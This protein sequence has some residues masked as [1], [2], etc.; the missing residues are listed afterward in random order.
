M[1]RNLH[2]CTVEKLLFKHSCL[3]RESGGDESSD[4]GTDGSLRVLKRKKA[5]NTEQTTLTAFEQYKRN[6]PA[7][8]KAILTKMGKQL[9]E[10]GINETVAHA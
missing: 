2:K 9:P 1:N 7:A 3:D 4:S 8:Y 10:D 5:E 6:N